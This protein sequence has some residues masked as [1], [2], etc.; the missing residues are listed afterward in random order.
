MGKKVKSMRS[1]KGGKSFDGSL[2][3]WLRGHGIEHQKILARSPQSNDVEKRRN[4]IGQSK[5]M[6]VGAGLE[7][8]FLVEV[9]A[10]TSYIRN[11]A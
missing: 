8:G 11:R 3:I 10:T 4:R 1:D 6:L 5:V 9:I 2:E 7:G